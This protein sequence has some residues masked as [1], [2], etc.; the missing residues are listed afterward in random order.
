MIHLLKLKEFLSNQ[1]EEEWR[2]ILSEV[3]SNSNALMDLNRRATAISI[4]N[5]FKIKEFSTARS[6]IPAI[7]LTDLIEE[8]EKING[9][10]LLDI[11]EVRTTK[12]VGFCVSDESEKIIGCAFVR[13]AKSG[14]KTPPNWDGTIEELNKFN[15]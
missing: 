10:N 7:G 4:K 14:K 8:L 12:W 11:Q 13:N 3:A 15:S 5:E 2:T 9:A 6:K 1:P